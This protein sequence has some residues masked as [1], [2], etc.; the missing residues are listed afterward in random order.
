M[1]VEY[2]KCCGLVFV[3]FMTDD[4]YMK[5]ICVVITSA[6]YATAECIVTK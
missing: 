6:K 5:I 4:M 2:G 3:Q 1:T